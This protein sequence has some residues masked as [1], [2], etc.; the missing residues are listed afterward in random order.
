MAYKLFCPRYSVTRMW[1]L[2][3]G[4]TQRSGVKLVSDLRLLTSVVDDFNDL[5]DFND[6]KD[7][8]KLN[9]CNDLPNRLFNKLTPCG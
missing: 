8:C 6:F 1:A 7:F 5:N 9:G 3:A 4:R 2:A